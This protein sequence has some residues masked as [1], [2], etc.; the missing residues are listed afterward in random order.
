MAVQ[1]AVS[2]ADRGG[3]A[4]R[5]KIAEPG[6]FAPTPPLGFPH[7]P[8]DL[9]VDEHGEALRLDRAFSWE[10]PLGIHGLMHLTLGQAHAADR[11]PIGTLVIFMSN[12]A[13]S[14]PELVRS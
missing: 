1:I 6:R 13:G 10:A 9:L 3:P 8:E 12:L 14:R 11:H 2:E 5:R 4:A 7:G